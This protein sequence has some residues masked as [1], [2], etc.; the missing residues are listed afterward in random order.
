LHKSTKE[1]FWPILCKV[2][3]FP[4]E[5]PFVVAIYCGVTK[6]PLDQYFSEFVTELKSYLEQGILIS[7]TYVKVIYHS[8][9]CDTPARA[10]IKGTKGH[11]AY[12]GCDKCVTKGEYRNRKVVFPQLNA[13]LRNNDDFLNSVYSAYHKQISPL[14]EIK[15]DLIEGFPID[16]MHSV[17]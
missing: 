13:D 2:K 4:T 3:N 8:F 5:P 17:C 11:N 14:I 10:F 9:C 1:P 12:Y 16:Y 7:N 6:P 15:M